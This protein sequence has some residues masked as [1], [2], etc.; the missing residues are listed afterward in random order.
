MNPHFLFQSMA[1]A[2]T[3]TE[4]RYGLMVC[5]GQYFRVQRWGIYLADEKNN[6]VSC[7]VRGVSNKLEKVRSV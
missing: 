1:S 5:L 6:L 7:D 4:S 3:E 2:K